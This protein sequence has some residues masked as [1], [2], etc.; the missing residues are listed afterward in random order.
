MAVSVMNFTCQDNF[1][2]SGLFSFILRPELKF[3]LKV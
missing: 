2:K 3:F 1:N